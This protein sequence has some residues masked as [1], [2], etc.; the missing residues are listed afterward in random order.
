[1]PFNELRRGFG[2]CEGF[3]WQICC[4]VSRWE[5]QAAADQMHEK[6]VAPVHEALPLDPITVEA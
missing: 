4:D 1:M 5:A 2:A 6:C 3:C